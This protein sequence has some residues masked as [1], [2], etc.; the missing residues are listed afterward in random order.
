MVFVVRQMGFKDRRE[1]PHLCKLAN[2]YIRKS[3]SC[4][5][6]IYSFFSEEPGADSL[7]IKLVEE[8]ERCILSYFAYHWSHADLMISQVSAEKPKIN[9]H[10]LFFVN[11]ITNRSKTFSWICF[12]YSAPM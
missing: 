9:F 2:E 4:E 12:R 11:I 8:F 3:G 5:E 6:D 10:Y 1:C 7:F